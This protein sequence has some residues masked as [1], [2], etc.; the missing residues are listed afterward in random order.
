MQKKGKKAQFFFVASL[1]IITIILSLTSIY[2]SVSSD[3]G[4]LIYTSVLDD[5]KYET[6]FIIDNGFQNNLSFYE[7]NYDVI[8]FSRLYSKNY[9]SYN[10][11]I[12]T[13]DPLT[14]NTFGY[15]SFNKGI[16]YNTNYPFHIANNQISLS[17]YSSEFNF[18]ISRG[19]NF[20]AIIIGE[21]DKGRF[22]ASE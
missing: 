11:T 8:N 21:N 17:L 1:I 3:K 16:L 13:G 7:I 2:N 4:D 14:L 10:F 5:L 15:Y 20:N 18:N 19:Y 12:I 9:P 22:I 6:T